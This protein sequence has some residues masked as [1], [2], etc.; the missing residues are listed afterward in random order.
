MVG[1][2]IANLFGDVFLNASFCKTLEKARFIKLLSGLLCLHGCSH[3]LEVLEQ[4]L[5]CVIMVQYSNICS[6]RIVVLIHMAIPGLAFSAIVTA[7]WKGSR[8]RRGAY[9]AP[10]RERKCEA[11]PD[12]VLTWMANI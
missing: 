12:K 7:P 10:E 11:R 3:T 8:T 2:L 5:C 6:P 4:S 9:Q 1:N